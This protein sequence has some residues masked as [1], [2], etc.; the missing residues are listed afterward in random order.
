MPSDDI[1][2]FQ[3]VSDS[4][5]AECGEELSRGR[6]LRLERQAIDLAVRAHVRHEHTRYDEL[7]IK[8]CERHE[9]RSAVAGEVDDVLERWRGRDS[10]MPR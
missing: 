3:L 8:E 1:V 6:M 5:C 4:A 10:F 9:A 7:L 2:V